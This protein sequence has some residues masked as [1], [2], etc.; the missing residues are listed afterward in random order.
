ME[1][2]KRD[3][4]LDA[5]WLEALG[6][7]F[8]QTYMRELR[9]FLGQEKAAGK[10]VYPSGQNIFAALNET[11]LP[12]VK[13]VIIGQDPYHGEGQAHGLSFS[14]QPG[15]PLPPSLINI[16]QELKDDVGD[17]EGRLSR[18]K[19]CLRPWAQQGVLLLNSVLTVEHS[20][21]GSHQGKG[22]ERFTDAIVRVL[23]KE[24]DALVFLLWGAYAQKKGAA[25]DAQRHKVL[26]SPHPSPLSAYR[27]FF[28]SRPFSRANQYLVAQ[29]IEP[30]DWLKVE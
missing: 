24:R 16:Y 9:R 2:P 26:S 17:P 18:D 15:T 14:V 6:D 1:Q 22:W 23:N 11:P 25:V 29:E 21:A 5:S 27:G 4:K 12:D 10:R 13:V 20:R 3:I 19:G 28:G 8:E 30:I 7:E